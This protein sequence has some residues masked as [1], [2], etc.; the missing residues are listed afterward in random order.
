MKVRMVADK[1]AYE[2]QVKKLGE[3]QDEAVRL[4]AWLDGH[5]GHKASDMVVGQWIEAL[6][7]VERLRRQLQKYEV[8]VAWDEDPYGTDTMRCVVCGKVTDKLNQIHLGCLGGYM[9]GVRY[10]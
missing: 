4:R 6:G 2:F 3:Y 5:P 7:N 1:P 9:R 10:G 8:E